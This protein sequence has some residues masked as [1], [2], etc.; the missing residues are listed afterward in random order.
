MLEQL[1]NQDEYAVLVLVD[2][3]NYFYSPSIY[4]SYR[5]ETDKRL[6]GQI[7]PYHLSLCRAFLNLDGHKIRHGLKVMASSVQRLQRHNFT[8]AKVNLPPQYE[9][10]LQGLPLDDFRVMCEYYIQNNYFHSDPYTLQMIE[11]LWMQCQGNWHQAQKIIRSHYLDCVL[12][13]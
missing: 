7:P 5:Y 9:L 6:R 2:E 10:Q 4:P 1:Y 12:A 13:F 11:F 3:F 8:A